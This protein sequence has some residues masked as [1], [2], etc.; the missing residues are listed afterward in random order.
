[1][2]PGPLP[3]RLAFLAVGRR[4]PEEE[5]SC[6]DLRRSAPN[7]LHAPPHQ[8][9][10]MRYN[11]IPLPWQHVRGK[12]SAFSIRFLGINRFFFLLFEGGFVGVLE[13]L[14]W[15]EEV[16]SSHWFQEP[17]GSESRLQEPPPPPPPPAPPPGLLAV[18]I[19]QPGSVSRSE[20]LRAELQP[21]W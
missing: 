3:W 5:P 10:L 18:L 2:R 20:G 6:S 8:V 17:A 11:G 19:L 16:V 13:H 15:T 4:R 14:C 1:M 21:P 9:W 7:L 12:V